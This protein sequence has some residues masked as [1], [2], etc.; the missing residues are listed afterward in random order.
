MT[1]ADSIR[2]AVSGLRGGFLRTFLTILSMAVGVSAVLTVLALS[3]AGE[4]RV[5]DE[6]A[7]LGVN[8]VW[9]RP[10]MEQVSLCESDARIVS[11]AAQAPACASVYTI[12]NVS[13]GDKFSLV[14]V[15]GF[16][17]S[18]DDVHSPKLLKGRMLCAS[19]FRNASAVCLIDEVLDEYMGGDMVGEY[20][21]VSNRRIRVVGVI[22]PMSLQMMSGAHGMMLLPLTSC[23]DTFGGEIAEITLSVQRGQQAS[24]VAEL[25]T[26]VLGE[27]KYRIDTLEKEINAAR[28]IV[29]IFVSVLLCVA[30]VCM[31]SGGIGVMN[32]LMIAVRERRRE[33]GLIKAIGGTATQVLRLFLVEAASYSLLGGMLGVLFGQGLIILCSKLIGLDASLQIGT[34]LLVLIFAA[35]LGLGFGTAPALEAASMQPVDA[36]RSD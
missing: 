32:V 36:L 22:K 27:E 12:A 18:A 14:Q 2:L 9:I 34:T 7:N 23:L 11:D 10:A 19:D 16:D 35:L 13:D 33:I 25:A 4:T 30:I 6:I 26:H 20:L 31:L 29:R 1:A 15:A 24:E 28:E 3:D 5:E 8:K 21:R 17:S